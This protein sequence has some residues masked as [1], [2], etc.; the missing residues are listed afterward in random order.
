V[1]FEA[2]IAPLRLLGDPCG[3]LK[4]IAAHFHGKGQSF[5]WALPELATLEAIAAASVISH[6]ILD[7][8]A[9]GGI[10][11]LME[12]LMALRGARPDLAL[13]LVAPCP[14]TGR[15]KVVMWCAARVSAPPAA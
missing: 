3:P 15:R 1:E 10:D 6:L 9:M 14:L 7:V 4:A 11:R 13:V 8:E 12:P 2:G 5:A